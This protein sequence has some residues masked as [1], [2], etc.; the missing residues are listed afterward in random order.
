MS[1]ALRIGT[2]G[3]RSS[4]SAYYE[5]LESVEVQHTFYQPPGIATLEGWRAEAPRDFE[6]TLKAWQL[7]TH[8]AS[9]PTYNR[10]KRALTDE[11][12]A[13]AGSFRDSPI[14]RE[15]WNVTRECARAL[16]ARIVLFQCPASFRPSE[17]NVENLRAFFAT[18]ERGELACAW[19][20]RGAWDPELIHEL[21]EE[22]DLWHA[23]D[24]FAATTV[25][26][27]RCYFR[28]HGRTGWRYQYEEEELGD[29]VSL[30]P[31]DGPAYV[32]FNNIRMIE[33]AVRFRSIV[34]RRRGER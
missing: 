20:P 6:F 32:Y 25:T 16:D 10:L 15:A 3:F 11:E 33:D 12:C 22:L 18:I 31:E 19:E 14:V 13:G 34:D 9:S 1:R 28:L 30:L 7:I 4:R 8:T 29:L 2:C 27:E 5:L 17:E 21:C 24:P 23:V 26:P